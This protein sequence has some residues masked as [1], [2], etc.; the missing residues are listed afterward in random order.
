MKKLRWQIVIILLTGL[1]VGVLLL[2]QQQQQQEQKQQ[3]QA[4][5]GAPTLAP[6]KGGIYT[7]ALV[8]GFQTFESVAGPL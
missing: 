8:G 3:Q 5:P 7:E 6:K 2:G 4:G 1:V